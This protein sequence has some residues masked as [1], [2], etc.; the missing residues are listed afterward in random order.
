MPAAT[1]AAASTAKAT[2]IDTV[3]LLPDEPLNNWWL[4]LEDGS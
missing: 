4:K 1:D 2:A 3:R